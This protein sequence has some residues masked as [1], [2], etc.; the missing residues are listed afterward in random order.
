MNI[1]E[2][3]RLALS[4]LNTNKL[5]SL[6]TLLGIIIGIMAVIIIMTLGR[7]LENDVMGGLQDAGTTTY[8]VM[9][10][11]RAEEGE[12]GDD[13]FAGFGMAGPTEERDGMSLDDLD[14]L[15]ASF[16]D[17]LQGVDI[18]ISGQGEGSTGDN[19]LSVGINPALSGSL[20]MRSLKVQYGRGITQ[21]MIDG[22]RPVAVVSPE[23]VEA[24]FDGDSAAA[25]GS[26]FDV[27]VDNNTSVFTIVGVLERADKDPAFGPSAAA[28]IFIPATAADR[29]GLDANWTSSFSVRSAANED[30]EVFRADLQSYLD[31]KYAS[32][33]NYEAEVFD[34]SASLEGLTTIFRTL[35]TVLSAIGGISLLV[36]GI[37]VMNIMLITVTER[38]REIGVRKAL[39]ATQ[40][41]IRVQFI[42]EAMLVCLIGG[43]IGVILG[44]AIGMIASSAVLDL[45][46]PPISAVIF[47]LLFSLATGVFFGAYPASKAA[48][49]Q[50]IDA[51]RYE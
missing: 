48:K 1:R 45:T 33:E 3:M 19:S 21:D 13:P 11:E 12:G 27:N 5:R 47:A 23:L 31:R 44:G 10:H 24:L 6:L 25:L 50:P 18:D 46:W 38:T 42:V 2:S 49:M 34:I 29:V 37:G 20:D 39:G 40:N 4:S 28:E 32:N 8:P 15:S 16:G 51:L 9:V 43:I 26:R 30:P 14:D 17:R 41:D 35:S 36:G 7:A 22:R